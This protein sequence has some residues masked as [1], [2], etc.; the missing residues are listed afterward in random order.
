MHSAASSTTARAGGRWCS[1]SSSRSR[2]VERRTRTRLRGDRA[3]PT[4]RAAVSVGP[5]IGFDLPALTEPERRVRHE[6]RAVV[7]EERRLEGDERRA[8][9][10]HVYPPLDAPGVG[11][12]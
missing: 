2:L 3:R 11:V 4:P 6:L 7:E 9:V 12:E 5:E 10:R 1:R 8:D